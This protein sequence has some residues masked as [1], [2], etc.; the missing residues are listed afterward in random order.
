MRNLLVVLG[1]AAALTACA[2]GPDYQRPV[3]PVP[4]AIGDASAVADVTLPNWNVYFADA[5]LQ[6]L[7][8]AA[9]ENNR[10]LRIATARVE[11]AR[12]IYGIQR[13]DLFPSFNLN[14][15]AV[16]NR[17]PVTF[18]IAGQTQNLSVLTRRYSVNLGLLAYELDFWGRVRRLTEAALA[19]YFATEE[20]QRAFRL[21]LIAEV[22][23]SYFTTRTLEERA[24]F[25]RRTALTR[26]E[27]LRV[28]TRRSEAGVASRLDLLQAE[29]LLEAARVDAAALARQAANA[30]NA[31]TV[32]VGRPLAL[33]PPSGAGLDDLALP[34]PL[35]A[36]LSSSVLLN[37]PDVLQAE[38]SLM[39]ANANIGAARA[40]FFPRITLVGA[41]GV[42]SND[43]DDLFDGDRRA[44]SFVPS[45]AQ[46]LFAGG[47]LRANVDVAEARK[48]AAVAQYERAIQQAFAEV[49]NVLSD[50]AWLAQ[51]YAAQERLVARQTERLKLA[52]ARYNAGL[53]GFL[54]VLD[55]Q[56]EQYAAQQA[57]IDIKR[58]RLAA[59]AQAYKALGGDPGATPSVPS[60]VAR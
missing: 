28:V 49:A 8:A 42:A 37:R 53:I 29:S 36:G 9:L 34:P 7:I 23:N 60:T 41:F 18:A 12:G 11:E 31:L 26:E 1:C 3:S 16:S 35:P 45:I 40:A 4:A 50:E 44:W 51:Q 20:A 27:G 21:S 46:P 33:P 6:E 17:G 15:E 32:L 24:E 2:T 59:A 22:A 30:R 25:A 38:Q 14:A 54:E 55:A 47:R 39:A 13:A 19:S 56:R 43:V 52:E 48:V 57:L 10:D 5:T 58:A